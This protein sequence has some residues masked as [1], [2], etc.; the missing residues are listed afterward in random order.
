ME[1]QDRKLGICFSRPSSPYVSPRLP[2]LMSFLCNAFEF[3]PVCVIKCSCAALVRQNCD[4]SIHKYQNHSSKDRQ[5]V[6]QVDRQILRVDRRVLKMDRSILRVD[7]QVLGMNK[8]VLRVGKRV[9]R[10]VKRV[11]RLTRRI[12]QVL[13]V[14]RG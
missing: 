4:F 12:V 5:I 13:R 10:M 1:K 2:G 6:L 7:R 8:P 3:L 9:L 11:L 14:T